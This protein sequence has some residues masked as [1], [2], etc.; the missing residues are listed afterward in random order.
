MDKPA[1]EGGTPVRKEKIHYGHQYIDEADIQAVVD[2]LQ[3]DFLTC[4]PKIGEL[5]QKLCE[6]TGAKYAVVCSN[7]TAALHIACLAAGVSEGDEVIT[8]PITFAASANC[9][10]YCGARP[11]FADIR[12]DTYNINPD[13]VKQCISDKSKAVVAVDFTGQSVELAPLLNI[14]REKNLVLIED[15][16]HV[17]GTKYKGQANGSLADMTTFSFHPVKTVTGGEGGAVLTNSE[18]YYQK[19]LLYRSHGIT[20][21][22]ALLEHPSDGPWYYEQIALGYNY[23]MT[24]MQAALII[25]QLDKLERFAARRKEIVRHYDEAFSKLP[26]IFIQKE[27]PESDTVRHL[28]ILRLVPEELRIDRKRFFEALEA[29]NICCNVHYI[30]TYYFPYYE[31]MGYHKGLCPNAEKL[32]EEIISLPLY[33]AMTDEDVESVIKAV[34]RIAEYYA[35]R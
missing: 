7:G 22:G 20:R 28:Y 19:L 4:G 32:Y 21:N 9:A 34:S 30:P 5:E 25:S 27:I 13:C 8:T 1:I 23:R 15:G 31:K 6:I 10:L 14:C 17:I 12:P 3:S 33:Y 11:V 2:V 18:E 24:D 16:A 26:G 35:N 29:E